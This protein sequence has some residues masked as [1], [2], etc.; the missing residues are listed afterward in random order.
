VKIA[1]IGDGKMARAIAPRAEERGHTVTG[2]I[3]AAKN[4]GGAGITREA[5]GN[6]DVAIE[7]TEPSA[8][9][10]NALACVRAQIP[11]VV[12]TTG[13]YERLD[14]V[15]A[16][17]RNAGGTMFWAPNFSIGVA[18]LSAAIEAATQALRGVSG[19]DVHLIETHHAAKKD[20]PSGTA[21]LLAR[22]AERALGREVPITSIRTGQVPG[23]HDLVI[24]SAFEQVRL[25]HEARDRRVFADGAIAAAEWLQGKKGIFTMN[26]LLKRTETTR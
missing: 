1:L 3:G 20:R 10:A 23:T 6:P 5:L 21:V 7:F 13:W 14:A 8:A 24:D 9:E 12:G 19:F 16:E 4:V 17:V 11:V 2:M 18:V 22:I 25:V 15:I 26:D